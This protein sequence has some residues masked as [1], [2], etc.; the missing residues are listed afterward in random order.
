[1]LSACHNSDD[2]LDH[3][4]STK[5]GKKKLATKTQKMLTD[6]MRKHRSVEKL[7]KS[8]HQQ[9]VSTEDKPLSCSAV[10]FIQVSEPNV[11]TSTTQNQ[12]IKK[13]KLLASS[14]HRKHIE[15]K[16]HL[17][18]LNMTKADQSQP[19]E[20]KSSETSNPPLDQQSEHHQQPPEAST[21]PKAQLSDEADDIAIAESPDIVESSSPSELAVSENDVDD[22]S[23]NSESKIQQNADTKGKNV[24]VPEDKIDF[25]DDKM[26]GTIAKDEVKPPHKK[27]DHSLNS[28]AQIIESKQVNE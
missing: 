14:E 9:H 12:H 23:L 8:N 19:S 21:F 17:S 18:K 4:F 26:N 7:V 28:D 10:G 13:A 11:K 6:K 16:H 24:D 1:M 15:H 20:T 25:I 27:R 2:P 5:V 3:L 22:T